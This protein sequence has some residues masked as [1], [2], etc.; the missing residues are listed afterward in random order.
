M[1]RERWQDVKI[2]CDKPRIPYPPEVPIRYQAPRVLTEMKVREMMKAQFPDGP[3]AAQLAQAEHWKWQFR[4]RDRDWNQQT[5]MN[6]QA[7]RWKFFYDSVFQWAMREEDRGIMHGH[8]DYGGADFN[9][10]DHR[11]RPRQSF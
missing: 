9:G 11:L 5:P 7:S 3:R 10:L 8:F 1:R 6:T 4:N 2:S